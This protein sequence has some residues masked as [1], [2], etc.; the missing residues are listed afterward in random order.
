MDNAICIPFKDL[1]S[2]YFAL[3]SHVNKVSFI[4]MLLNRE[5]R[6]VVLRYENRPLVP[7]TEGV[8]SIVCSLR[9]YDKTQEAIEVLTEALHLVGVN[10]S[11]SYIGFIIHDDR[12]V[13]ASGSG[14]A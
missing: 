10:L 4:A 6:K 5:T 3:N 12:L 8:Y 1:E 7:L 9:A 14:S 11:S 2:N 13:K